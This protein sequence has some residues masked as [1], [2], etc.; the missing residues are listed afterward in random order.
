M[1]IQPFY[2]SGDL[3]FSR[4]LNPYVQEQFEK[5]FERFGGAE[6]DDLLD[7]LADQFQNRLF[8]PRERPNSEKEI[9]AAASRTMIDQAMQRELI[10]GD[11]PLYIQHTGAL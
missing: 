10:Y 3:R 6:H 11:K 7:A 5:Q 1:A 9:M 8:G 2:K 4:G